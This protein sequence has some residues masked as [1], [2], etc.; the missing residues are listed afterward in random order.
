V[1]LNGLPA[2]G[3]WT[4][5]RSPDNIEVRGSGTSLSITN[6]LPGI[7]RFTV[8][9]SVS[10]TSLPSENVTINAF[11]EKPVLKITFP[12]PVCFP[13]TVDLTDNRITEGSSPNI[14]LT[15]WVDSNATIP[16]TT[17]AAS[18][19]GTWYIK[20]S[21]PNGTSTI[22]PVMVTVYH[23]PIADAGPD[24]TIIG[25]P[26]AQLDAALI[27]SYETGVWTVISGHGEFR[28]PTDPKTIVDNLGENKNLL[29]W[30]VTNGVCPATIDTMMIT[31]RI[32]LVSTFMTPN[33]D[34]RN[35]YLIIKGFQSDEKPELTIFDRRGIQV[36]RNDNYNNTW[37]GIDQQGAPLE[38]DTYFYIVRS[39]KDIILKGFVIIKR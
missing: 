25:S 20:G 39:E 30:R 2:S 18:A 23:D 36:Y 10:C 1:I 21:L 28:D 34:G 4:V 11:Q 5:K 35:D 27:N 24:Q 37:N 3:S 14:I 8:T 22:A 31:R 7:Y 33:M 19:S 32:H 29:T 38:N 15:Y 17:P 26:D 6:L 12:A 13:A 16:L 9:N